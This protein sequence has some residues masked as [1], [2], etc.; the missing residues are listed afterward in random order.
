MKNTNEQL[1]AE[2]ERLLVEIGRLLAE[3]KKQT[4]SDFVVSDTVWIDCTETPDSPRDVCIRFSDGFENRGW[5]SVK[6]WFEYDEDGSYYAPVSEDK[7][8]VA[9]REL[10]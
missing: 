4:A 9:W 8:V 2:I 6:G 3:S 5:R 10:K 1:I 7:K